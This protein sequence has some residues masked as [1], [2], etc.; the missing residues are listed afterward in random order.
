M[1]TRRSSLFSS[2]HIYN[3]HKNVHQ[4]E[5]FSFKTPY[6]NIHIV[7][8]F[9]AYIQYKY[10]LASSQWRSSMGSVCI[11]VSEIGSHDHDDADDDTQN[12]G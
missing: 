7:L 11:C 4:R 12:T 2:K 6:E 3:T 5:F 10:I 8:V 9:T 1:S